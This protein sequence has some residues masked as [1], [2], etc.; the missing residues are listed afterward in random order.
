MSNEIRFDVVNFHQEM[1]RVEEELKSLVNM[2]IEEKMDY[3]VDTLRIVTPVD[4]GEARS[5]WKTKKFSDQYGFLG[6][7]ILNPVDHIVQLNN[8]HSKQA[9][10]YFIEQVLTKIGILTP[11]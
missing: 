10:K 6:G 8:G 1:K 7:S 9:P 4:T 5:G 3:S 11:E 2:D